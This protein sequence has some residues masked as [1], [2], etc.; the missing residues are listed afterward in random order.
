MAPLHYEPADERPVPSMWI[1]MSRV[2][3][4]R[5]TGRF[6]R[7]LFPCLIWGV[8]L[9]LGIWIVE[10]I[11]RPDWAHRKLV[12]AIWSAVVVGPT[13]FYISTVLG[14]SGRAGN[15]KVPPGQAI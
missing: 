8:C 5:A 11:E 4:R 7:G 13:V 12:L 15:R 14:L 6:L 1:R 3:S 2:D 9:F 10:L